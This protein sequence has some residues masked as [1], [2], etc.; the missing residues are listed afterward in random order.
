MMSDVKPF[1]VVLHVHDGQVSTVYQDLMEHSHCGAQP[2]RWGLYR[3][4]MGSDG[5]QPLWASR[6]ICNKTYIS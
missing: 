5:V 1:Q 2:L 3:L 6:P 4:L